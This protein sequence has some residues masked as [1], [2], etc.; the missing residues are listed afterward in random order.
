MNK[1][2]ATNLGDLFFNSSGS[3]HPL[4]ELSGVPLLVS[5]SV[6]N[7]I[8]I[9]GITLTIT[10]IYSAISMLSASGN[11]QQFERARLILT[12]AIIGF[13]IVVAAWFIVKWI[14]ASTG[15]GL[16]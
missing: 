10:I 7:A 3:P 15:A 1:L 11:A 8:L 9:A 2:L 6:S 12:T 16:T 4:Q 5:K 13:V 14:D